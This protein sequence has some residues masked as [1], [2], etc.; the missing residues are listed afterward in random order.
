MVGS[1]SPVPPGPRD[2]YANLLADDRIVVH[3]DGHD[4]PG[5]AVPVADRD[6][7][8]AFF[9]D[10]RT[11]WYTSQTELDGLIDT[12]PMVEVRLDGYGD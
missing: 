4:L 8:R 1:S 10:A 2:W 9:T 7:R 6:Y 11:S 3:A 5:T 12:A